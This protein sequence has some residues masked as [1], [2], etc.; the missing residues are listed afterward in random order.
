MNS[1][2]RMGT[3]DLVDER[4][5]AEL[6][7][8]E[9]IAAEFPEIELSELRVTDDTLGGIDAFLAEQLIEIGFTSSQT[10]GRWF[11]IHSTLAMD[12]SGETLP[13]T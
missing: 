3:S 1:T 4:F 11:L 8:D 5:L 2:E 12:I 13:P 6:Q 9:A 10:S 7:S